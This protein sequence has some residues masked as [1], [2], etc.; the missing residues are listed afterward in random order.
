MSK[1]Y[2]S[3]TPIEALASKTLD[4]AFEANEKYW[5]KAHKKQKRLYKTVRNI[6][7]KT[8]QKTSSYN[9]TYGGTK[10]KSRRSN[11]Q[12]GTMWMLHNTAYSIVSQA[13]IESDE[14][15]ELEARRG[16]KNIFYLKEMGDY[17]EDL[18]SDDIP[19][20]KSS[21]IKA[22]WDLLATGPGVLV[23]SWQTILKRIIQRD[24]KGGIVDA[25]VNLGS[26]PHFDNF[27]PWDV[28]PTAGSVSPD[29]VHEYVF[30]SRMTIA[31]LR[32]WERQ[33]L[34]SNLDAVIEALKKDEKLPDD[35]D[36]ET[37][38]SGAG[39][40]KEDVNNQ[41]EI[42]TSYSLFPFYNFDKYIDNEG[43]DRSKDEVECIMIK[44]KNADPMLLLDRNP[45]SCQEKPVIIAGFYFIPGEFWPITV[46]EIAEKIIQHYEDI[47]NLVQDGANNDIYPDQLIPNR[48][49]DEAEVTGGPGRRIHMDPDLM[50]AGI[51]PQFMKRPNS[52]LGEM[53]NQR[54]FVD[55]LI[56]EVTAIVDFIKGMVPEG[57]KR[58]ATETMEIAQRVNT[59]FQQTAIRI[60][61]SLMKPLWNWI[62]VMLS[63]FSDDEQIMQE[64]GTEINPFKQFQSVIPNPDYRI[65]LTGALRAAESQANQ[66]RL[67]NLIEISKDAQ[68]MPD[69]D[70]DGKLVIP[71]TTMMIFDLA[72]MQ[73]LPD[74]DKYKLIV[75]PPPEEEMSDVAGTGNMGLP[76]E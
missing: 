37:P 7:K 5:R 64:M 55:Q 50:A 72:K 31:E 67:T 15:M 22:L 12:I 52:I 18:F 25:E 30:Q 40:N 73:G 74:V 29:S 19:D 70:S 47:F 61:A 16:V 59:R 75:P 14:L 54:D 71:N 58:T 24:D 4:T 13:L 1:T 11:I 36:A 48:G 66:A 21:A 68:P 23:A 10:T 32:D 17:V 45:F 43:K 63:E 28:F 53:Y 57:T 35:S 41:I 9:R 65:K 3:L 62:I 56:Q 60:E 8:G 44:A 6:H 33:G 26:F 76:T 39:S 51:I 69:P 38:R 49:I 46:F 27:S 42:L 34:I 2:E 20:I